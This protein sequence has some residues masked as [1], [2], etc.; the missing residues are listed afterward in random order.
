MK[1]SLP[2]DQADVLQPPPAAY[3]ISWCFATRNAAHV[4]HLQTNSFAAHKALDTFYNSIVDLTDTFAESY[5]GRYGVIKQYPTVSLDSYT[6]PVEL[7]RELRTFID[8]IRIQC[9][10]FSELQNE[11]DNIVGLCNKTLYLL[12]NLS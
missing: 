6:V 4:F 11:I 1:L 9:G 5:Q 10:E 7:V 12:E 8:N 2:T 3:L